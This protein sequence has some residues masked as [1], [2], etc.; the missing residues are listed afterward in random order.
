MLLLYTNFYSLAPYDCSSECEAAFQALKNALL[1]EKSPILLHTDA[2][3]H[4][5]GAVLQR[6]DRNQERVVAYASRS[7]TSAEQNYTI[8]EQESLAVVARILGSGG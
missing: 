5:L 1:D 8:T 7:L 2:S 6:D 4:G 3:G